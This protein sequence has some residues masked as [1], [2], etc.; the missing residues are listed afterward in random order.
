M[1]RHASRLAVRSSRANSLLQV[2][3]ELLE[4]LSRKSGSGWRQALGEHLG[5]EPQQRPYSRDSVASSIEE[6]NQV[7]VSFQ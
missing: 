7:V 5:Q 2:K 4:E 6:L 1:L 3:W